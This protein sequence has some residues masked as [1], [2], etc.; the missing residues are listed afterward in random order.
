MCVLE[1]VLYIHAAV[2]SSL[3]D[4]RKLFWQLDVLEES[5]KI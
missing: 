2:F 5:R 3:I 1:K 4:N